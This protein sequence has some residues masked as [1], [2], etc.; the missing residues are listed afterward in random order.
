M[1]S[2]KVMTKTFCGNYETELTLFEK[3]F[4]LE[5]LTR[6]NSFQIELETVWLPIV[7]ALKSLHSG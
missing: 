6:V 1:I 4:S 5:K 7:I 2:R 3:K